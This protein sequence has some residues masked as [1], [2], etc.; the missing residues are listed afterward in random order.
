MLQPEQSPPVRSVETIAEAQSSTESLHSVLEFLRRQYR[1]IVIATA[2]MLAVGAVYVVTAQSS[3]TA[4]ASMIIDSKRIQLFQQQSMF[5][6]MPV[7]SGAVE[8]QV[9]ILKSDTI[10]LAVIKKLNLIDD[11]EFTG[12][13]GG[14]LGTLLNLPALFGSDGP[15]S[16]FA[17]TRQAV[18]SLQSRLTVRRVGLTYVIE[19]GFRSTDPERAAQIANAV[20]DAYIDD[21]LESKFQAARRAGVWLQDRLRELREQASAAEGA[22]VAFKNSNNMVD[23]GGRTI[24]EQQLA[25]LNSQLVLAQSQTAEARA[26][27]DRVEAVLKSNSPEATVS[28]TVADTL[29]N[30]VITKLRSQYLELS[31]R[32][33]DWSGRYG[34][35]HL[36]VINLRNQI[37]ELQNSIRDELQRIAETYKSDYE[38]AKQRESSVQKQLDDAVSQSQVTN[39]AQVMLRELE[40][41]A[42]T[43]RALYDNFLQRYMESVQQQ[44]FPITEARV[45]SPASRPLSPSHPRTRLAL[46]LSAMIGLA[47]GIAAGA[48]RDFADRVFRTRN[49]VE[50]LLRTECIAIVPMVKKAATQEVEPLSKARAVDRI[51]K[52]QSVESPLGKTLKLLRPDQQIIEAKSGIYSIIQEEPF[53]AFAEAIR[54]IKVAID[55]ERTGVGAKIIGLTSSLPNEGKSSVAMA[56]ARL[57]AQSGAKTLLIDCDLKN[58]TLSRSLAPKP[59]G[60]LLDLLRG[61]GQL[62]KIKWI[63]PVTGMDFIPAST[64]V[65]LPNSSEFLAS[66]QA[67]QL[68]ETLRSNYDY[69]FVDFAP[70]MPIVDV[71]AAAHL[72]DGYIFVVEWGKTRIDFVEQALR[73]A[74]GVYD[75]LL[76]VVLNKVELRAMGRYDGRGSR[77]YHHGDYFHRYGYTE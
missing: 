68:F 45:I 2:L 27:F 51:Q 1:V 10:A 31:R 60:G 77:Y 13:G 23:A 11:P 5:S 33:A 36:A 22:V 72:V 64:K 35:K 16:E 28:A 47:F 70:L 19:I 62:D 25:E 44:S 39:K 4:N 3:Y 17:L 66:P 34:T 42:Q 14:I 7:D 21:Q 65:R 49:Q 71:R 76:G 52:P 37:H 24:N 20:A 15:R 73:S 53:S 43:Y 57:A 59:T 54:S 74:R 6:D 41:N 8:S 61:H 48:W 55:L 12:P 58:P 9:E 75:H 67:R 50:D 26:R 56:T 69:I 46:L 38:I 63:D 40:S 18:R 32:E 29:K 30:D